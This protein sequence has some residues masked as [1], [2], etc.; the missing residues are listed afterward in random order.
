MKT[1][2]GQYGYLKKQKL[3]TT[4]LTILMFGV[5]LS[6]L[7][8]GIKSTGSKKNLLTVVAIL[9]CLPASKSAVSM[10]MFLKAK[11]CSEALKQKLEA[12]SVSVTQLYD[13]IFTSYEKNYQVSHMVVTGHIVCGYSEDAKCETGA[14]EKHLDQ[15]LKRGGVKGVTVKIYKDLEQ[16]LEGI[17]NLSVQNEAELKKGSE[18]DKRKENE[19]LED[20]LLNLLSVSL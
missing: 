20:I 16:Y 1:V 19:Q 4:I 8:A 15:L 9:G 7:L 10:I 13:L 5:S 11:G 14:C 6:L 2:K 18:E 3:K 17:H 12:C